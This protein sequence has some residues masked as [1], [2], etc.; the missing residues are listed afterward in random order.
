MRKVKFLPCNKR[1]TAVKPTMHQNSAVSKA[2]LGK[3]LK[4]MIKNI[5]FES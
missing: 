3:I 1:K 5:G 2:F 4:S